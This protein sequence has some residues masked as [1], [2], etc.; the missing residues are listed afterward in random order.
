MHVHDKSTDSHTYIHTVLSPGKHDNLQWKKLTRCKLQW[1][2]VQL[3]P[4][5]TSFNT[6]RLQVNLIHLM[7][8]CVVL[9][10]IFPSV[11]KPFGIIET[12]F[13]RLASFPVTWPTAK[14][15]RSTDAEIA[16]HVSCWMQRLLPPKC[17]TI[18]LSTPTGHWTSCTKFSITGH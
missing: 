4:N 12:H 2:L 16:R 9:F 5:V 15:R 3:L 7:A 8:A 11:L 6:A 1:L 17:N 14:N 18:H 13:Y 10:I